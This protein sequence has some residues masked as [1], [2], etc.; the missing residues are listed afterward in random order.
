MDGFSRQTLSQQVKASAAEAKK[1]RTL[2]RMEAAGSFV[3]TWDSMGQ[4]HVI[5]KCEILWQDRKV[6]QLKPSGKTGF[7]L[8]GSVGQDARLE[9]RGQELAWSNGT[10]WFRV[11][12][13]SPPSSLR[14]AEDGEGTPL[15]DGGESA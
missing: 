12:D 13:E 11:P 1:E 7:A 3:G 9:A 8:L 6:S 5:T 4:K 10:V 15:M 2:R 14:G